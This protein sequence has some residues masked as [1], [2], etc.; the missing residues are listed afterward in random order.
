MVNLLIFLG[1]DYTGDSISPVGLAAI[2]WWWVSLSKTT[3]GAKAPSVFWAFAAR[4]K[5]CPFTTNSNCTTTNLF[6]HALKK[7]KRE[8]N[9][10]RAHQ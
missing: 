2:F 10:F 1:S 9:D 4:L 7:P 5:S 6:P 8:W 3:P